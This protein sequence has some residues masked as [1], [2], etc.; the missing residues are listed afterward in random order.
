M[1]CPESRL[2][3]CLVRL[4]HSVRCLAFTELSIRDNDPLLSRMREER[5]GEVR[6]V[7]RGWE[8]EIGLH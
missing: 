4:P 6:R 3:V 8:R 2:A 5:S 7:K 1:H